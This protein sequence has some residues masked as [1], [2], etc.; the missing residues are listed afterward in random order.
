MFKKI[1]AS[2]AVVGFVGV[3]AAC[4]NLD[5]AKYSGPMTSSVQDAAEQVTVTTTATPE[6]SDDE[7]LIDLLEEGGLPFPGSKK[8]SGE[9]YVSM[10]ESVCSLVDTYGYEN[11]V[12]KVQGAARDSGFL[13]DGQAEYLVQASTTVYCPEN[14]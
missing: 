6:L 9:V 8:S 13:T 11:A 5:D 4:G 7:R 12:V 1:A 10:A 2:V 3:A 14:A